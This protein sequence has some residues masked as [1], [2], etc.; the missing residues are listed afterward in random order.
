MKKIILTSL[1]SVAFASSVFAAPVDT[2]DT[3]KQIN[4][5]EFA[6]KL[7]ERVL[8]NVDPASRDAASK[9]FDEQI[10]RLGDKT[11]DEALLDAGMK[12]TVDFH[13]KLA[14]S[15]TR[16]DAINTAMKSVFERKG[17]EAFD[18]SITEVT[19]L[20]QITK[21]AAKNPDCQLVNAQYTGAVSGSYATEA[22]F[23]KLTLEVDNVNKASESLFGIATA[24]KAGLI[25]L[26]AS[27]DPQVVKGALVLIDAERKGF[28]DMVKEGK[29]PADAHT[30]EASIFDNYMVPLFGDRKEA[31]WV[32]DH[33]NFGI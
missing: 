21:E 26:A 8:V 13:G 24:S 11:T 20:T 12:V 4:T 28:E 17:T 15:R 30:A 14:M 9:A 3:A 7:K 25:K 5:A 27:N 32:R 19:G 1:V 2:V 16:Y 33:C 10:A 31:E 18:T 29:V 6:A 22:D 23:N